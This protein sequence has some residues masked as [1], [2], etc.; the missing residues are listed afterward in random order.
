MGYKTRV[1][2]LSSVAIAHPVG[3]RA[4]TQI[5]AVVVYA[6]HVEI[7]YVAEVPHALIRAGAAH[8]GA[9]PLEAMATELASG[10]LVEIDGVRV[11]PTERGL[12]QPRPSA[13]HT[14]TFTRQLSAPLPRGAHTVE[15]S[16]SNLL[17]AHN[18]FA[19]RLALADGQRALACTVAEP[20]LSWRHGDEHRRVGVA[21]GP[22][23]PGWLRWLSAEDR[24]LD[25]AE[26]RAPSP[27]EALLGPRLH[28][29]SWGV[30]SALCLALGLSA[31]R[32][33]PGDQVVLLL[34]PLL[35]ALPLHVR[36]DALCAAL[37]LVA[38]SV[39]RR[40]APLAGLAAVSA[41]AGVVPT[42]RASLL[43]VGIAAL[44]SALRQ[45]PHWSLWIWL[46]LSTALLWARALSG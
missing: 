27:R 28:P 21:L 17:D 37:I 15:V 32:G 10:L 29:A 14:W 19:Q 20:P 26:A 22:P 25:C 7:D 40:W 18:Y 6:D 23:A 38:G 34:G 9:D 46:A 2:I 3:E 12:V 8:R 42:V 43:L 30:S 31:G 13:A 41:L 39:S 35:V 24:V 45:A 36:A 1:W 5:T 4:A 33:R 16:T 44:G 11:E